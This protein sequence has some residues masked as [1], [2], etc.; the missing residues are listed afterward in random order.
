MVCGRGL[1]LQY[2]CQ[3]QHGRL[4][5]SSWKA[6]RLLKADLLENVATE[7]SVSSCELIVDL[8]NRRESG[9]KAVLR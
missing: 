8:D 4:R 6:F 2:R 3:P 9:R 1:Y 7:V 5:S